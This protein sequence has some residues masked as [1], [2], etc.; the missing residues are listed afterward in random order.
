MQ[1]GNAEKVNWVRIAK[2]HL[3]RRKRAASLADTLRA[4]DVF[5]RTGLDDN[6]LALRELLSTEA[7]CRAVEVVLRRI[8]QQA[9][10]E[11][12]MEIITCGAVAPYQPVLGGKLVAMLMTSP[13]V[14]ADVSERY[15]GRVSLIASGMAGRAMVRTPALSLLTT[16]SLYAFGSAQYNRIRIPG[17]VGGAEGC[18]DIRYRRIGSTA[19]FGTVQFASDTTETLTAAAR[20]ANSK[21]R[22]V[23]NLFGEGMSPKLRSLRLGPRRA[24]LG[25]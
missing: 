13:Q 2:T 17:D 3:Y 22:L 24:R 10:A 20:L 5:E 23:N 1:D 14:V 19:S 18:G 11:N 21:R 15:R 6:P 16:S 4:I 12:V 25:A 7:G 9:I 8:K